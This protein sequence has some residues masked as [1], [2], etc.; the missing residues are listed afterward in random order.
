MVKKAG[1]MMVRMLQ[2]SKLYFQVNTLFPV[3]VLEKERKLL[4]SQLCS[5]PN[6]PTMIAGG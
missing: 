4:G 2:K 1:Y 6:K 5:I 3:C